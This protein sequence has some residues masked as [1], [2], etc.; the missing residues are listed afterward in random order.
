MK[1][2]SKSRLKIVLCLVSSVPLIFFFQNCSQF[3]A[4]SPELSSSN[5][6]SNSS[7]AA[8]PI[9]DESDD[10]NSPINEVPYQDL[11]P[12]NNK[13]IP[14]AEVRQFGINVEMSSQS[15]RVAVSGAGGVVTYTRSA[16]T[17]VRDSSLI[18]GPEGEYFGEGI[19]LSGSGN[20]LAIGSPFTNITG[21]VLAGKV[22][23]YENLNSA[24]SLQSAL[25]FPNDT[26][27][28]F[29]SFG[30]VID[31]D[32]SGTVLAVS[33][34]RESSY[35]GGVWI[36][37]N[38]GGNWI[39]FSA[40]ISP[41][42]PSDLNWFGSSLSLSSDGTTLAVGGKKDSTSVVVFVY[43]I[44]QATPRL[45]GQALYPMTKTS[46]NSS[47]VGAV[48]SLSHDGKKLLVGSPSDE[49]HRGAFWS[50]EFDGTNWIQRG[51]KVAGPAEKAQ[52]G[53][54][55]K[56]FGKDPSRILVGALGDNEMKGTFFIYKFE[57]G[58]WVPVHSRLRMLDILGSAYVG[59]IGVGSADGHF[60]I[61]GRGD[62]NAVGAAW[63]FELENNDQ[64]RPIPGPP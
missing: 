27:S 53:S 20:I 21:K 63:S 42:E 50:Y 49:S 28:G 52:F 24:W 46:S 37:R 19:A 43:D 14:P 39:Q 5:S 29:V 23:V 8:D 40:K 15:D 10:G 9:P 36:Y 34:P 25:P 57:G 48:V 47:A 11:S 7:T 2:I 56:F 62:N 55:V 60:W 59:A 51:S 3:T 13:I 41:T 45:L 12:A 61:T 64:L 44:T 18:L 32:E 33:G 38:S 35:R 31:L 22:Q 1:P 16:N 58:S 30:T 4:N 6:N 26:S 54:S 17:W